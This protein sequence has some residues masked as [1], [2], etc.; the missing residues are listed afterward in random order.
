MLFWNLYLQ[1]MIYNLICLLQRRVLW[2]KTVRNTSTI[3]YIFSS[4]LFHV[5]SCCIFPNNFVTHL[6]GAIQFVNCK[7]H[8]LLV[9]CHFIAKIIASGLRNQLYSPSL[10]YATATHRYIFGT[11]WLI[12]VFIII[13]SVHEIWIWI[14]ILSLSNIIACSVWA[15]FSKK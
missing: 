8:C 10:T 7:C 6:Y 13:T 14:W 11:R 2:D 9:D 12:R 4:G 1:F 3:S 15:R 5:A